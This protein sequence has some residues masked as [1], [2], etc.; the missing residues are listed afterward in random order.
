MITKTPL[1]L[2]FCLIP[3]LC[4]SQE[5]VTDTIFVTASRIKN[6]LYSLPISTLFISQD[7]IK[8]K[9]LGDIASILSGTAGVDIRNYSLINGASTISLLGAT[10]Q[11]SLLLLD[12]LAINSPSLGIADIGLFP[13]HNLSRIEVVKGPISSL[14]G[15]NALAGVVNL[16]TQNP[17]AITKPIEYNLGINYGSFRTSNI[18]ISLKSRF[19]KLGTIFDIYRSQTNGLRTNDD[20]LTQGFGISSG[21]HFNQTN[22]IRID[23]RYTTKELGLPGPKPNTAKIPLYGDRTATSCFNRQKDTLYLIK[24]LSDFELRP[25]WQIKFNGYYSLNN[26]NFKWVD[27]FS[28]DTSFYNDFYSSKVIN[29]NL[30][31]NYQFSA[32]GNIVVGIDYEYDKFSAQ[33]QDTFWHPRQYKFALFSEGTSDFNRIFKP[34]VS[35]RFD[36]HPLFQEFF[37]PALGLTATVTPELKFRLH[38]GR[39]FRAPTMNDMYWPKSAYIAGN[40][41][42]KPEYGNTGQL[43]FDFNNSNLSLSAT[44]FARKINNLISWLPLNGDTW[45]PFNVDTATIIGLEFTGKI[46]LMSGVSFKYSGTIQYAEQIRK[47]MIFDDW[48]TQQREFAYKRRKQ[49][50]VPQFTFSPSLNIENDLGTTINI[51]S[52]YVSSRYNYYP[53]YDS[54]PQIILQTKQLPAYFVFSLHIS[55]RISQ[56]LN[57]FIKLE[58]LFDTMFSEQFGNSLNDFDYPRPGRCLFLGLEIKS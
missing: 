23:L 55:Q 19:D 33:T 44:M 12:G 40:S 8:I 50:Y 35:L 30:L 4:L 11:Q 28:P 38:V 53:I 31:N 14:Y 39:A 56:N 27:Q 7:E 36:W 21:Y 6:N 48:F 22:R 37:S 54:L 15:A 17:F 42:I 24:L 1:F 5:L 34:F 29:L 47:E 16:I 13:V 49:A 2:L 45:Q 51:N 32:V 10:S 20:C 43:G 9:T 46:G 52:R 58:N 26:T 41:K 25:K 18:N 57:L 3:T